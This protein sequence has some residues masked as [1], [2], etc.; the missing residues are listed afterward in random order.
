MNEHITQLRSRLNEAIYIM[1]EAD[2]DKRYNTA[3]RHVNW[4]RKG[5]HQAMRDYWSP[6]HCGYCEAT[7][8]GIERNFCT[9]CETD[10]EYD[11]PQCELCGEEVSAD[12][13]EY[14][15][16]CWDDLENDAEDY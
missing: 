15:L 14:C 8:S 12:G 11:M 3:A 2:S 4:L 6:R 7:L 9:V 5:L 10:D 1:I 13:D 16:A